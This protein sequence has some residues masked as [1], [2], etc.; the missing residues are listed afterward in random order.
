MSMIKSIYLRPLV[1]LFLLAGCNPI[2]IFE[3]STSFSQHV[4]KSNQ[5]VAGSFQ[6][7]DTL[8]AYQTSF[9]LR[10]TD[11]YAYNNIWVD[12][13]IQ[14]PG[15]SMMYKRYDLSLGN[16][17]TGWYGTG[18]DDIWEVRLPLS[19]EPD[20]FKKTGEYHYSIR[21][22]MRDEELHE[23]MSAGLRVEKIHP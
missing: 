23:V 4:W 3:K 18:M 7:S 1:F 17:A 6:I 11:A 9:V 12:I 2:N 15:D 19:I 16:D 21:Q 13:G 22:L 20:V 8:T 10:H 5:A 14:A